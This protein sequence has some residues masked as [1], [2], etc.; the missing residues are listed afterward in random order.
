[1]K[2]TVVLPKLGDTTD[3]VVVSEWMV[4]EGERVAAGDVVLVVETDKTSAEVESPFDG[5]LVSQLVSPEQEIATG[6]P[7][8]VVDAS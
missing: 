8:F 5:V 3:E 7:V 6:T 4:A 1:M 2:Q